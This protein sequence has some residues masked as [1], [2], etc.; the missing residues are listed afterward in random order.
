[1]IARFCIVL[2]VC[3]ALTMLPLRG[4]AHSQAGQK[5]SDKVE[6]SDK[7]GDVVK[8]GVD[9][10]TLA[11]TSDGLNLLV[12]I[13]VEGDLTKIFRERAADDVLT[14]NLDMDLKSTTGGIAFKSSTGFEYEVKIAVCKVYE[15]NPGHETVACAGGFKG[16]APKSLRSGT[17]IR[18]FDET[19]KYYK[20]T[21]S[22]LTL[23]NGVITA[24][25]IEA[26]IPYNQIG[27]SS[28]QVVR[29]LAREG[30]EPGFE[31]GYFPETRLRL[32]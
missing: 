12:T 1:M 14:L 23:P 16:V 8:G 28:A 22:S 3:S 13:E 27:G 5:I 11:L 21:G 18:R 31:A 20:E 15:N 29:I 7:V 30:D 26:L 6:L 25:K 24:T 32:K 4:S 9:V 17:T 10:K 2:L 19:R